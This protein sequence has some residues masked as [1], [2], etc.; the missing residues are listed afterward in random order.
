M[1][2]H[3]VFGDDGEKYTPI[4]VLV[5]RARADTVVKLVGGIVKSFTLDEAPADPGLDF[6][7]VEMAR[8]GRHKTEVYPCRLDHDGKQWEDFLTLRTSADIP[9]GRKTYWR[10]RCG[11]YA[12]NENEVLS[13]MR[14]LYEQ[15]DAGEFP[16]GVD[17]GVN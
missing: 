12:H 1:E 5:N 4:A 2:V 7:V 17:Y 8:D 10:F 3:V 9:W 11:M 15:I 13:K 6:Y 14:P 16:I